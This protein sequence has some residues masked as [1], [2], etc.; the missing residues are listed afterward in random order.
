MLAGI[1][2]FFSK[3]FNSIIAGQMARAELIIQR[4]HIL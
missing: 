1:K 4:R 3:L 2:K